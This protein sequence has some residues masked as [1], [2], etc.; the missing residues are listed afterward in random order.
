MSSHEPAPS[1]VWELA[2]S[3]NQPLEVV[4]FQAVAYGA[5]EPGG[6]ISAQW[7]DSLRSL[8]HGSRPWRRTGT[9][10]AS[11]EAAH[12]LEGPVADFAAAVLTQ[13]GRPIPVT[14]PETASRLA[15]A[16]LGEV[17][18]DRFVG[19]P[20]EATTWAQLASSELSL[21]DLAPPA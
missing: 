15:A 13:L 10:P 19:Y 12:V 21:E 3:T 17:N 9:A 18:D 7:A 8:L 1:T 6:T 14:D 11:A 5:W 16:G 4:I 2:R 20:E